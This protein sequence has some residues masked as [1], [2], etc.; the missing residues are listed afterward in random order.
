MAPI[1]VVR[2]LRTYVEIAI[3]AFL[4]GD[5]RG[6]RK[7]DGRGM[8]GQRRNKRRHR[9]SRS[10]SKSRAEQGGGRKSRKTRLHKGGGSEH[11]KLVPEALQLRSWLLLLTVS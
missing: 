4:R 10:R 7:E 3:S 2:V 9:R 11:A 1:R 8:R 5:G 6:R